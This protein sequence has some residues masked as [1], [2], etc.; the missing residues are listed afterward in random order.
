MTEDEEKNMLKEGSKAEYI[1][2][3]NGAFTN[4]KIY[5]VEGYD[6]ELDAYGAASDLDEVYCVAKEDLKEVSE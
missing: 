1:G 2:E 4:G 5:S 6:E 3:T